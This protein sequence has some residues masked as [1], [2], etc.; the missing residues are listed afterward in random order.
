[1]KFKLEMTIDNAIF[2][3]FAHD[4][5]HSDERRDGC[6]IA[7]ILRNMADRIKDDTDL[8]PGHRWHLMDLN[9]NGVGHVIID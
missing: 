8:R 7:R 3:Q 1:M 4:R 9:G 6:E 5:E 2:S